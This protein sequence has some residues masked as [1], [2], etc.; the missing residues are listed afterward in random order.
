MV[1]LNEIHPVVISNPRIESNTQFDYLNFIVYLIQNKY[2]VQGDIL[3]VD[4]ASVHGGKETSDMLETLLRLA[5][6]IVVYL[7]T[8]S[9]EL[10]PCELVFMKV[11]RYIRE[12][13]TEKSLFLEII[14]A[15]AEVDLMNVKRFYKKCYNMKNPV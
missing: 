1:S 11:K 5:G 13:R 10:N 2:L 3:V 14:Q 8:Y 6:V 9:P 15:F 12:H 7:P 4:N